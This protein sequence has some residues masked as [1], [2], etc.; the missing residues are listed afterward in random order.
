MSSFVLSTAWEVVQSPPRFRRKFIFLSD[1]NNEL[2]MKYCRRPLTKFCR[3]DELNAIGGHRPTVQGVDNTKPH[4]KIPLTFYRLRRENEVSLVVVVDTDMEVLFSIIAPWYR[5]LW[6]LELGCF[7][8]IG[9]GPSPSQCVHV[10]RYNYA[11]K[12]QPKSPIW[13]HSRVNGGKSSIKHGEIETTIPD[14]LEHSKE[15]I[16]WSVL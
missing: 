8:P 5:W 16:L 6:G 7:R 3:N 13:H 15:I 10:A 14:N 1:E 2:K 11:L 4:W 9:S 12:Q